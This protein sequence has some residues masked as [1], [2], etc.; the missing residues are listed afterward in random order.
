MECTPEMLQAAMK[1]A[2]EVGLV[3]K[4]T[5]GEEEYLRLWRAVESVVKAALDE[6]K[7]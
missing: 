7:Q 3:P 4:Y 5:A 1:K 2:V 6:S